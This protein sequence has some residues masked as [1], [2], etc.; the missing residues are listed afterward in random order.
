MESSTG[1]PVLTTVDRARIKEL[2]QENR[3][4]K[5]AKEIL[6]KASAYLAQ[7]ELDRRPRS[8]AVW[9]S[10]RSSR[11]SMSG[12]A[13]TPAIAS[14]T[15]PIDY[16]GRAAEA[17]IG[18]SQPYRLA[19]FVRLARTVREYLDGILAFLDSRLTNTRLEGMTNKARLDG[20]GRE[21]NGYA[22]Q[23]LMPSNLWATGHG[24]GPRRRTDAWTLNPPDP[25]HASMPAASSSPTRPAAEVAWTR[26]R[27]DRPRAAP[28]T[29]PPS[30]TP[31]PSRSAPFAPARSA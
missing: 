30:R 31:P 10:T 1:R 11:R 23:Q 27:T 12:S 20:V 14:C 25:R 7:A 9:R 29:R 17:W 15:A 21:N 5:R 22:E 18:W 16:A 24:A 2:E 6:R 26:R 3:E 8:A 13:T 28:A 19:P 4:L